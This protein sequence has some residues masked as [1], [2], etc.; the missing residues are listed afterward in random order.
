[1]HRTLPSLPRTRPL[2]Q[3]EVRNFGYAQSV[4]MAM[5]ETVC[6]LVMS[7]TWA[8]VAQLCTRPVSASTSMWSFIP[9]IPVLPLHVACI[10]GPRLRV[11]FFGD[12]DA[13]VIRAFPRVTIHMRN[14]LWIRCNSYKVP[15]QLKYM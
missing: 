8:V 11:L 3:L 12:G 7:C 15:H 6:S 10:S 1:M 9:E 5:A 4:D 14:P 2:E 13:A